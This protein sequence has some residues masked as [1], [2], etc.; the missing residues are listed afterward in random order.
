LLVVLAGEGIL[1]KG[2]FSISGGID[3]TGWEL[4]SDGGKVTAS[5]VKAEFSRDFSGIGLG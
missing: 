3:G 2:A 4:L 5:F 1:I